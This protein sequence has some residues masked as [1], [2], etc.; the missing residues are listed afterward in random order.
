MHLFLQR[1]TQQ[2]F[3]GVSHECNLVRAT[4]VLKVELDSTSAAALRNAA[5]KVLPCFKALK[6]DVVNCSCFTFNSVVEQ[7]PLTIS[8]S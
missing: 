8:F 1:Y 3:F 5:R 6:I 7:H 2:D 4:Y